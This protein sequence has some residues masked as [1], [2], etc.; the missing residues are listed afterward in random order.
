M[1][2]LGFRTQVVEFV[3][4]EATARN[5][6]LKC[7]YGQKPGQASPV[8]E[9]LALRDY[10]QIVPWLETRLGETLSRHLGRFA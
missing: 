6:M 1:R 10:W 5:V 9:Y 3:A 7:E 4:R 2:I 8:G